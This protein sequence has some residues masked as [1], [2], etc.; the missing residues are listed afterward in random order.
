MSERLEFP[1]CPLTFGLCETVSGGKKYTMYNLILCAQT[2]MHLQELDI[3]H[4]QQIVVACIPH[5]C[6]HPRYSSWQ[7]SPHP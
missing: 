2:G 5:F 4:I 1:V 7:T 3:N 6:G